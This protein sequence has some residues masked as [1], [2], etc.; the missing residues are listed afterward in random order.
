MITVESA[1][2]PRWSAADNTMLD[3]DVKFSHLTEIVPFTAFEAEDNYGLFTRA[4]SGEFGAIADYVPS[5]VPEPV[6]IT[7]KTDIWR[8]CTQEEAELLDGQLATASV[9]LRRLWDD[10]SRIEHSAPEFPIL[11]SEMVNVF[12]ET[13]TDEIL[14]PSA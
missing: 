10:A 14:A 4:T 11:R 3:L 8:R 6:L 9:K 1:S 12:G 7:F 13:R 5:V 2:S